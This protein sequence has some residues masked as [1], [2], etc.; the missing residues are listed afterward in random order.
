M[1]EEEDEQV[2]GVCIGCLATTYL[3]GRRLSRSRVKKG[4]S[5]ARRGIRRSRGVEGLRTTS[6]RAEGS[7]SVGDGGG[8][9]LGG[10]GGGDEQEACGVVEV[11]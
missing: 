7:A 4:S 10:G 2:Q 1:R 5:V 6:R 8:E 3:G 11:Y 9:S